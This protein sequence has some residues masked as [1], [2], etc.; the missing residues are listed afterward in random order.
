MTKPRQGATKAPAIAL[1]AATVAVLVAGCGASH[2][3]AKRRAQRP[4]SGVSRPA[5]TTAPASTATAAPTAVT[6]SR[7]TTT[8]SPATAPSLSA[9][10]TAEPA[11][12]R[13]PLT[14]TTNVA[15]T[16]SSALSSSTTTVSTSAPTTRFPNL[17]NQAMEALQPPPSGMEAPVSLP[18]TSA[19]ISAEASK[20]LDG[21]YSVTLVATKTPLPVNS[22]ELG[23]QAQAQSSEL[24]TF[25][26][27][28]VASP[29]AAAGYIK[30]TA[31]E[32]LASCTGPK[33]SV[34]LPGAKA[35][36]CPTAEGP[37]I[38]WTSGNWQIQ[39]V[40]QGASKLPEP[41][42]SAVASWLQA[43]SLPST[44]TGL[45]SESVPGSPAAG[46]E[47]TSV[48]VWYSSHDVY[49]V[50]APGNELAALR[51]ASSMRPWPNG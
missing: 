37:A 35:T 7:A 13:A 40:E 46:P 14:S 30:S 20:G 28:P 48:V 6:A 18:S 38:S 16:T 44:P 12:S 29:T 43:N 22:P 4:V 45:V 3:A 15:T 51:L 49:Q 5:S 50:S 31:T 21:S 41:A 23:S 17:V 2:Q 1:G 36:S 19:A 39:V 26:T 25:S 27:T 8:A 33:A 24:G 10:T 32:D 9:T 34:N 47:V 11:S 42:A